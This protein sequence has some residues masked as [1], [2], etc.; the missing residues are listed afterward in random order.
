[1]GQRV[2]GGGSRNSGS[3][4]F[5]SPSFPVPLLYLVEGEELLLYL[6]PLGVGALPTKPKL[7]H[8][9][10]RRRE[11]KGKC[12]EDSEPGLPGVTRGG[13]GVGRC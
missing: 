10:S 6:L 5:T 1:M 8:F 13:G 11:A 7:H 2:S 12:A 9:G 3:P 4:P